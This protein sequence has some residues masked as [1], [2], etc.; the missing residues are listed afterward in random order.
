[1]SISHFRNYTIHFTIKDQSLEEI[2]E[3][4]KKY[5]DELPFQERALAFHHCFMPRKLVE[6]KG[7]ST[8][9]VDVLDELCV[10]DQVRWYN[11]TDSITESRR[12]MLNNIAQIP[13]GQALFVGEIKEGVKEEYDLAKRLNID[14]VLIS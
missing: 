7:F 6:E 10:P 8:D 14:C 1:M 2:K 13:R 4:L 5:L 11:T 3:K 12:L 9:L